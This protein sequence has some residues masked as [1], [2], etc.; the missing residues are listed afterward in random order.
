MSSAKK[1][2]LHLLDSGGMYGAESVIINLSREMKAD[3]LYEPVVGCI[4]QCDGT[5]VDLYNVAHQYGIE[6]H[7][8]VIHNLFLFRD[9]PRFSRILKKLRIDL[10]HS[11][12]YKASV[13][14]FV[15]TL[16]F[17]IPVMATCH[18]WFTGKGKRPLKTRLMIGLEKFSYRFFPVVVGVSEDIRN[19]LFDAGVD[20]EKLRVVQNGIVMSDYAE[21]SAE[22][23]EGLRDELGLQ[24]DDFFVLNVGRL[25]EQKAQCHI[26]SAA[27]R[28]KEKNKNVKIFIVGDGNLFEA[29][30][31]QIK[32]LELKD[33]VKLLGF[34]DD[35]TDLL[36]V[37]DI[38]ILPSLD[39]GMPIALL[40]AVAS[41]V[42]VIT[43]PVGDI[44]KLIDPDIGGIVGINDV[45]GLADE[46][47][48]LIANKQKQKELTT[49]A[50]D[51]LQEQYSSKVMYA[52]YDNI[53]QDILKTE[54]SV[55]RGGE[56]DA[57]S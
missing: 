53:Y 2:I 18:L 20:P 15:S 51:K 26:I 57:R 32:S 39:E 50:W 25:T 52:Q 33:T 49:H 45:M 10:I 16:L 28:V 31:Q 23:H 29:L 34:R 44:T 17:D 40:E 1:R 4:V 13:F 41:R 47:T 11:H 42:P 46:I 12:G 6:A 14:A 3:H 5:E 27:K 37:A 7:K 55:V 9:L 54:S 43:T 36:Q 8:I 38:F 56:Y 19:V 22:K 48:M 35:I 30:Q 24:P 21:I